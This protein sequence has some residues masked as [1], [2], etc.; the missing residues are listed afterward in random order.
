MS[1]VD[2]GALHS[3][4]HE[5]CD[6]HG[7]PDLVEQRADVALGAPVVGEH[8]RVEV[9]QRQDHEDDDRHDLG[10]RDDPVEDRR[11]L[12]SAPDHEVERPYADCGEHDGKESVA[13]AE[14]RHDGPHR[15]HDQDPVG[16]VADARARPVAE[17]GEEAEVLTEARLGVRIDAGIEVR[18]ADGKGLEDEREHQ[19]ARTGDHPG[20]EGSRDSRLLGEA[21][22]QREHAGADHRPDDHRGHRGEGELL[23]RR[24]S[25]AGVSAGHLSSH[26]AAASAEFDLLDVNPGDAVQNAQHRAGWAERQ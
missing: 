23:R 1:R 25:R 4:K 22:R 10:D 12:R 5:D 3:Q 11:I 2:A 6:E 17:C 26:S 7:A 19:H 15:R 8:L 24:C 18:L 16:D 14:R 21:T 13:V 20:D 9:E